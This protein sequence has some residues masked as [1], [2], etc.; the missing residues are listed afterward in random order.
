MSCG[1]DNTVRLFDLRLT[2]RCQKSNCRDNILIQGV[3]A[4][5]AMCLSPELGHYVAVGSADSHVRIYDRRFLRA[6]PKGY[7]IPIKCFTIPS[8]EQRPFRVTSVSYNASGDQLL[9][10]YSSDHLYIFDA[11]AAGLDVEQSFTVPFRSE[12]DG[13]PSDVSSQAELSIA[14]SR[15]RRNFGTAQDSGWRRP[16]RLRLR[17]DWSDTGP[18]ARP[19]RRLAHMTEILSRMLADPRTRA[20]LNLLNR[21]GREAASTLDASGSE[22]RSE[23]EVDTERSPPPTSERQNGSVEDR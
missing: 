16:R 20:N 17:G 18:D 13:I 23:A 21:L 14:G 19:E 1:E 8:T 12:T 7:S 3:T 4:L 11:T 2:S 15:M 10:S 22:E 5:T 6:T 9:V